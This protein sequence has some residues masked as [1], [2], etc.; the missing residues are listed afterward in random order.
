LSIQPDGA[1]TGEDGATVDSMERRDWVAGVIAAERGEVTQQKAPS[2]RTEQPEGERV[3]AL[4]E[5]H[6]QRLYNFAGREIAYHVA[7]GDL[8]AGDPTTEDVVDEVVLRASRELARHLARGDI[9]NW[10]IELAI[11]Q[12]EREVKRVASRRDRAV[13]IEDDVPETPPEVAVST[14]GDE[15]LD[16]YQPD[17]DLKLE[18]V[19]PDPSTLT[20]EEVTQNRDLQRVVRRI[21]AGLPRSWRQA[22]MLHE[23]EGYSLEE[24]ARLVRRST[25]EVARDLELAR[26]YLRQ[27]LLEAGLG[28]FPS[29]GPHSVA[30]MQ[31]AVE[32][33]LPESFRKSLRETA[34]TG[35]PS[36]AR[37]GSKRPEA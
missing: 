3:F 11:E 35:K 32:V 20:P 9:G 28:A 19:I 21:V 17:E 25:T 13:A 18:D 29:K 30:S 33:G 1:Q 10:L 2:V 36:G 23:V 27:R 7:T 31:S 4:L 16:S 24:T 15:I 22:F 34:A 6:L 8:V 37:E 12:L 14:L 26:E 5:P